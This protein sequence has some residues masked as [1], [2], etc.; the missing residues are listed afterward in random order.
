LSILPHPGLTFGQLK[1]LNNIDGVGGLVATGALRADIGLSMLDGRR[2]LLLVAFFQEIGYAPGVYT[3]GIG[4]S[5]GGIAARFDLSQR[6]TASLEGLAG[7]SPV[8]L[9][10]PLDTTLQSTYAELSAVVRYIFRDGIWLA[11]SGSFSREFDH[12]VYLAAGTTYDTAN[13]VNFS[14]SLLL[15][16]PL[17]WHRKAG[18]TAK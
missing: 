13:S 18:S 6:L 11:A 7:R 2:S 17:F 8:R 10:I 4:Y 5:E 14:A 15:G 12:R 16:V 9:Q 1:N 3:H